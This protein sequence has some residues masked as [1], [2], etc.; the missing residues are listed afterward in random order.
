MTQE[1]SRRTKTQWLWGNWEGLNAHQLKL[2]LLERM[3]DSEEGQR[4][5]WGKVKR[6]KPDE[7]WEWVGAI[8]SY[9]Y[10]VFSFQ[11]EAQR[12]KGILAHRI[13]YL[14]N[15]GVLPDELVVCHR[16]DNRKCVNPNH[17]FLGTD[18]Q[19]VYDMMSK[20]RHARGE[21]IHKHKLTEEQVQNVR[22]MRKSGTNCAVISR[23]FKVTRQTIHQVV[24]R[25]T[26]K[27][28]TPDPMGDP[29]FILT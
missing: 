10:G 1:T 9:G 19:N 2:K 3:A 28:L 16:C 18:V 23:M 20:G 8:D 25:K 17:L 5:F 15:S 27:H 14:L 4:K 26:W 21:M 11:Y 6:V 22:S 13:S 12:R 7:C 29:T 24:K